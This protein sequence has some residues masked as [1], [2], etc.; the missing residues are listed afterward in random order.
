[1][2]EVAI[3]R[4]IGYHYCSAR[5]FDLNVIRLTIYRSTSMLDGLLQLFHALCPMLYAPRHSRFTIYGLHGP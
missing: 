2:F 1:M 5:V 3:N 4:E